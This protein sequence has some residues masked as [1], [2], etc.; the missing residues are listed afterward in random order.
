MYIISR[1]IY[2][3]MNRNIEIEYLVNDVLLLFTVTEYELKFYLLLLLTRWFPFMSMP[4]G[5]S[6]DS[7]EASF[8]MRTARIVAS[9]LE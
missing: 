6:N 1:C 4:N 7:I 9:V 2:D 5:R 3:A 8:D